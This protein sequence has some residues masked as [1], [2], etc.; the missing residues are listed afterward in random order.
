MLK[1][2]EERRCRRAPALVFDSSSSKPK[3]KG[4]IKILEPKK[5][6]KMG[7]G[8]TIPYTP[9]RVRWQWMSVSSAIKG[10]LEA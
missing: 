10:S 9:R 6:V 7:K 8:K 4:K 2:F 5:R 1:D 3:G